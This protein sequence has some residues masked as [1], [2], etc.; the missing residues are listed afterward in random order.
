MKQPVYARG[1]VYAAGARPFPG[2]TGP[3]DLDA[4]TA[5]VVDE[6]DAV[7]LETELPEAF[8]QAR[9]GVVTGRDLERVRFADA[10]FEER[11]GSPAV[12]DVDL[13]GAPKPHDGQFPAGP[14]ATLPSGR[15]RHRVW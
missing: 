1:N 4:G 10:D 7:Y 14:L 11:D 15:S 9:T 13:S 12:V 6:G 8:D 3:L 5:S 2:E